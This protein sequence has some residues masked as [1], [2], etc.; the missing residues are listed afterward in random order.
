MVDYCVRNW[1]PTQGC[2]TKGVSQLRFQTPIARKFVIAECAVSAIPDAKLARRICVHNFVRTLE[3]GQV[4]PLFCSKYR[5]QE[6]RR[7]N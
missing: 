7:K 6:I 5:S 3:I 1:C 2:A 4:L